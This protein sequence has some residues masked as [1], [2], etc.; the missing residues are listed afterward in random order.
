MLLSVRVDPEPNI[1]VTE[2]TVCFLKFVTSLMLTPFWTLTLSDQHPKLDFMRT[3]LHALSWMEQEGQDLCQ[4]T[5]KNICLSH[6]N[7]TA[8]PAIYKPFMTVNGDVHP[9]RLGQSGPSSSS[10]KAGAP[11]S[12]SW[13]GGGR[14][15]SHRKFWLLQEGREVEANN[16]YIFITGAFRGCFLFNPS[17]R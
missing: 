3:E 11:Q 12:Q 6:S 14:G 9:D 8:L 16:R 1:I 10:G 13:V 17:E 7:W 2:D 5:E 4:D 15:G